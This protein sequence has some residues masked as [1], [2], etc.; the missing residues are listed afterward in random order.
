FDIS[1]C[2]NPGLAT[3]RRQD[4]KVSVGL[5]QV[6]QVQ[7]EGTVVAADHSGR[8]GAVCGQPSDRKKMR[9]AVMIVRNRRRHINNSFD[10]FGLFNSRGRIPPALELRA[11][12]PVTVLKWRRAW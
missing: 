1:I 10:Q 7:R 5:G 3:M 2:T 12:E 9:D 4:A 8:G 11:R 6:I